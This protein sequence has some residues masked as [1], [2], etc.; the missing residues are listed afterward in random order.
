[1]YNKLY[2]K[3]QGLNRMSD[4]QLRPNSSDVILQRYIWEQNEYRISDHLSPEGRIIDIGGHI[5][6]FSYLCWQRGAKNIIA[7][8]PNKENYE[9]GKSNLANTSVSFIKKAVWRSDKSVNQKLF[10][11]EFVPMHPD[12]PDPVNEDTMNTGTSTVFGEE[13][14]AVETVS[15]D[16]IIGNETVDILKLDC[17]GSEFPIL[18]TSQKLKQVRFITGEYHLMDNMPTV[19]QVEGCYPYS[20]GILADLLTSLRFKVEFDPYPDALFS[21]NL[22]N[23]FAYNLD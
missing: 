10:L 21:A 7:F 11:T 19:A 4:F 16:S 20:V 9:L 6:L 18:L 22:G 1:M 13:G 3:Q 14:E 5:G 12:G 2:S 15:L 8:E 17:E 23:F